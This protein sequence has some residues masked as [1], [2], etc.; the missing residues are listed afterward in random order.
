KKN[1]FNSSETTLEQCITGAKEKRKFN[2]I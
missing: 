2:V 1:N